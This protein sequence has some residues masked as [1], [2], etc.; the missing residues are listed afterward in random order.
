MTFGV[1]IA[2]SYLYC[3]KGDLNRQSLQTKEIKLFVY[4]NRHLVI[5]NRPSIRERLVLVPHFD[6]FGSDRIFQLATRR[7]K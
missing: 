6:D 3:K 7:T 4:Y 5:A 2:V 1:N